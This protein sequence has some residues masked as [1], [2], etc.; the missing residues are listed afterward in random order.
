MGKEKK[1]VVWRLSKITGYT[2]GQEWRQRADRVHHTHTHTYRDEIPSK[3]FGRPGSE[4]PREGGV[5]IHFSTTLNDHRTRGGWQRAKKK[6]KAS[7]GGNEMKTF[8]NSQLPCWII[9][10]KR[11]QDHVCS[12]KIHT[13][14]CTRSHSS[15]FHILPER[16]M[17]S[18]KLGMYNLSYPHTNTEDLYPR[19]TFTCP[20]FLSLPPPPLCIR[21]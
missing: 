1:G 8:H 13:Y 16:R 4:F 21:R 10:I 7:R 5:W 19:L 20:S 17:P 9:K 18:S 11:K 15:P 2:R 14:E 3:T 12:L 6:E